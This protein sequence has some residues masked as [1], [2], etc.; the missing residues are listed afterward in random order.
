MVAS[1]PEFTKRTISIAGMDS[2]TSAAIRT[3]YSVGAP[4]LVPREAASWTAS[5]TFG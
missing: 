4:K 3:S 1:V 2:C 5:S